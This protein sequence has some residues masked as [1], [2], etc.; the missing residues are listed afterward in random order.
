MHTGWQDARSIL[1]GFA[2][3]FISTLTNPAVARS[4]ASSQDGDS[5]KSTGGLGAGEK[6]KA[7]SAEDDT[8]ELIIE[9]AVEPKAARL[10]YEVS[11]DIGYDSNPAGLPSSSIFETA[12]GASSETEEPKGSSTFTESARVIYRLVGDQRAGLSIRGSVSL[13]QVPDLPEFDA[14]F[15]TLG[16]NTYKTFGNKLRLTGDGT[17]NSIHLNDERIA[18]IYS[19]FGEMGW[20][21]NQNHRSLLNFSV[22]KRSFLPPTSAEIDREGVTDPAELAA[23]EEQGAAQ[24]DFLQELDQDGVLF[25]IGARHD[26]NFTL[27]PKR[28]VLISGVGYGQDI[29]DGDS[30]ENQFSSAFSQL[31]YLLSPKWTLDTAFSYRRT[32]YDNATVVTN[33]EDRRRDLLRVYSGGIRWIASKHFN[34]RAGVTHLD[35]N[36]SI[37]DIYGFRRTVG[38]LSIEYR[39]EK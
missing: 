36:S 39:G 15:D 8:V 12:S 29:T 2:F 28:A 27:G 5:E 7:E 9:R 19:F 31:I 37:P 32:I 18:D 26:I 34:F 21:H 16:F 13:D 23:L 25:S 3:T 14:R 10:D 35:G 11:V 38:L 20:Q 1:L 24:N 22:S 17:Y 30:S 6:P 33:F 4:E